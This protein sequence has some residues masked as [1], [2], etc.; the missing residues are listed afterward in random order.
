MLEI[1]NSFISCLIFLLALYFCGKIVFEK[2]NDINNLKKVAVFI[3]ICL[4]HTFIFL[5]F[6]GT[7]K[8]ILT[9]IICFAV[10]RLIFDINTTK[11]FLFAIIYI[12]LLIIPELLVIGI[13]TQILGINKDYYYANIAGTIIGN[14]LVAVAMIITVIAMKYP[15]KKILNYNLSTSKK[16]VFVSILTGLFIA[17]FFYK[18]ASAYKVNENII[19]Y[20][21]TMFAFMYILFTLFRQKIEN[22]AISKK[23]DDLLNV[24]KNYE[25]DIEEQR[26]MVHETRNELMTIKSKINDKEK[27]AA[28]IKYIDSILGDKVSS[29]MSKY[30]KFKYLPSNGIKGFFYYKFMEAEKKEIKVSVN[31]SKKIENSFLG[32]LDTK[33]FKDLVRII[34]V[35]LDNAIDAS[36]Q[37]NDKKLGIEI[38]LIK[39]DIEIIISNTFENQINIEKIGKEKFTTKGKNHGHGLLLVKH[40]LSSTKIFETRRE[41]INNLYVQKLTIKNNKKKTQ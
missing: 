22:E 27:E 16:I 5:Y 31:I 3:I 40:I 38:Y 17:F 39:Q 35:Y 14:I 26:I 32:K 9:C 23:Y 36:A 11:A 15:L 30:S 7:V 2:S 12:I 18:F 21:I 33:N 34:G 1:I 28:I 19:I 4:I 41:I 37:S 13:A 20:L 6:T 24:M 10:V 8:T 25:N 29:N